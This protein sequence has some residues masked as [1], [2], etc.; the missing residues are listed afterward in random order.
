M[1]RVG[2]AFLS[3]VLVP[4]VMILV[5]HTFVFQAYHVEGTSMVQT[6]H[7]SDYLIVSKVDDSLAQIRHAFDKNADYLPA[8]GQIIV[9]H[10]PVDPTEIFVKRVIALPGERVVIKNGAVTVYTAGIPGGFDP[11]T[12]YEPAGTQTLEDTDITVT[13]GHVFVMGDNR[14]PGGSYDSRAWGQ[15]PSENIIGNVVIRLLPVGQTKIF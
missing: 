4:V 5:L 1:K 15:L 6:L 14:S 11:D 13:R 2:S 12:A 8:R 10:Y 7:N 9:F 3:W